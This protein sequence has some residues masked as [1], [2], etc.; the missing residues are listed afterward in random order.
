LGFHSLIG[1]KEYRFV[2]A[3]AAL[4]VILAAIGSAELLRRVPR[5]RLAL[6]T[7]G[8]LALWGTA[9]AA[10]ELIENPYAEL[11]PFS[12]DRIVERH[13]HLAAIREAMLVLEGLPAA[14][15]Y[16]LVTKLSD[17]LA[18]FVVARNWPSADRAGRIASEARDRSTVHIAASAEGTDMEGLVRHLRATGHLTAGLI[19]RTL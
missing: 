18:Q 8:T 19:L 14:T 4:L 3:S 6:A 17:T 15:R 11:A 10:L 13:G 7:M 2:L 16:A 9:S 5:R 12:W 1:H